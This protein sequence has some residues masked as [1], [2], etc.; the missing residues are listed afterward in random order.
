MKFSALAFLSLTAFVS[1]WAVDYP[2]TEDSKVHEGVPKGEVLKRTLTNSKTFPGTT[3]SVSI[4]VPKQYDPAKP[5]CVWVNQDGI[6]HNAPTVF[7]NL[8]AKG[9]MPVT[10][11]IAASPG[12][13]KALDG[14]TALDR[15]NRSLEYDG[16]GDAYAGFVLEE[17]L[18]F[19]ERQK[20]ADGRALVLSKKGNDRCIGGSSSGAVCAFTA[21]WEKPAEFR[22]VFSTIGTYVGLR[23]ADIY[24]TLI[25]KVEPKSLRVFLQDGSNDQNI[26][27]GDWWMANQMME[28]ALKWS[29]YEVEH[30]WGEEGHN[31]KQGDAIFPDAVRWIWKDWPK[32]PKAGLP[33][34]GMLPEVLLPGEGWE[35]VGEAFNTEDLENPLPRLL[36]PTAIAS[37]PKGE[38]FLKVHQKAFRVDAEG[39]LSTWNKPES[40]SHGMTFGPTGQLFTNQLPSKGHLSVQRL[41]EPSAEKPLAEWPIGGDMVARADG[42]LF[43]INSDAAN[44]QLPQGAWF[45]SS[46]GKSKIA[47][48]VYL[49]LKSP[50]LS[51]DQ[52]LL[53]AIDGHDENRVRSYQIQADGTLG[54]PEEQYFHLHPALDDGQTEA[55]GLAVDREGRL[56]VGTS[57]GV[58][59]C[60]QAGR[61][62]AILPIPDDSIEGLCFGGPTFDTLYVLGEKH[63]YRR[64]LKI[65]GAPAFQSP[66]K[67][68]GPHL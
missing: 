14:K 25:R 10:I 27:G 44:S 24:P 62:N 23:G 51:P 63:L 50:T 67:P 30:A 22:R 34:S 54:Q 53:Y 52:S 68:A 36:D 1:L 42:G 4:Y 41:S 16:L 38:V 13:V 64:K 37:N 29:G 12:V 59:I 15:F 39:K 32:E 31:A 40:L 43:V 61:V 28:R 5:A 45:I 35:V 47:L 57:L 26:Y 66:V 49:S 46:D 3:R 11:Y 9:E 55:S 21:A 8:I 60:D 2:L 7:D 6:Q 33:K 17:L 58:Q 56:Y 18:P 48:G 19:V 65:K 20:T